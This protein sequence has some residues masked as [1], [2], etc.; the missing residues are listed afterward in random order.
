MKEIAAILLGI[1]LVILPTR[2]VN[3]SPED[4]VSYWLYIMLLEFTLYVAV[5][6]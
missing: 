3:Y 2:V 5:F 4:D 6:T 1:A